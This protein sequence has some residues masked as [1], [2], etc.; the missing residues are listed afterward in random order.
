M[1]YIPTISYQHKGLR[2][3]GDN[4]E[5]LQ[6]KQVQCANDNCYMPVNI[7]KI[8]K[9]ISDSYFITTS[10]SV[11]K[12]KGR[13]RIRG[14]SIYDVFV[15]YLKAKYP[16]NTDVSAASVKKH[17]FVMLVFLILSNIIF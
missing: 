14:S 5:E 13:N 9:V 8:Y 10:N 11:I 12:K 1:L 15:E 3:S 17:S 6:V 4:V 16:V 7:T 2:F